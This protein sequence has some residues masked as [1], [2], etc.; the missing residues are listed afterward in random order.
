MRRPDLSDL[1]AFAAVARHR[2][3][4]RA[5]VERGVSASTLSDAVR[6]LEERLGVRLLNR[7]TRSVTPTEA[8]QRLLDR[9]GPALDEVGE[10]L[11]A[12]NG[13]RDTPTGTLRLN[14]PSAAA[15]L[16]LAPLVAP[17]LAAHP[18]LRL[19][20]VEDNSF[21]DV[22][23]AGFDA[24]VRY[25]EALAKDM[26]AV[27]LGPPQRFA[28]AASPDLLARCGVPETPHALLER[29][30]IRHRFLSGALSPWEFAR[31]GETVKLSPAGPLVATSADMAVRAAEDG[32]GFVHTFE[33]FLRPSLDA[34]RLV[35]VLE[36]WS[37][38]FPGPSLYY[39]SRRHVP[40]GLR[41]FVEFVRA[42]RRRT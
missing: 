4:R 22:F 36:E 11:D 18:G 15:H 2:N 6:A 39:P 21:V 23:A 17:F 35:E 1:D 8:G 38:R 26:I 28:V 13:F 30:C 14:V 41:A 7:T 3:F 16:V 29:P 5:A 12:V 42:R 25:D 32:V 9:L 34:G 27:P 33:G 10:A 37:D 19:E 24:G 40:A 31:D 20:I